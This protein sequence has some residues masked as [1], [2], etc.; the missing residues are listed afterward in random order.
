MNKICQNF[1]L[2]RNFEE[3]YF[4]IRILKSYEIE[5]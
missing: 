1:L 2:K 5:R 4:S 3:K